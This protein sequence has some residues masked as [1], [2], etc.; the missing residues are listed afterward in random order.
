MNLIC[1]IDQLLILM[2][3]ELRMENVFHYDNRVAI[4][5]GATSGIGSSIAYSLAMC[6]CKVAVVGRNE[7]RARI[8]KESILNNGGEAEYFLADLSEASNCQEVIDRI[9]SKFG[10]IDILVNCAGILTSSKIW[11]ITE[12]EWNSVLKNN[13]SSTFFMI[14]K[15]LPYLKKANAPRIINISSNAGRM[16]GYENSQ[17]YTASKGGIDAITMGI[18]RQLAPEGITVNVV[19]PGTTQTDMSKEYSQEQLTRLL[20]RIPIGRLGKPED[21]A[22]AVCFFASLESSFITGAFLDV[23][24]GMYMG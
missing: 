21:T 23:N 16:G 8:I 18:A 9:A 19:C 6:G 5:T 20:S 22:A 13:L 17:A 1:H 3:E 7:E 12:D 24:G 10:G 2:N 11:D 4:V 14:Q 15:C